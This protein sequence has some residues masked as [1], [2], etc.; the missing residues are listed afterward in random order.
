M[1]R[2]EDLL[3]NWRNELQRNEALR[4]LDMDELEQHLRDSIAEL[5]TK[6]LN[7][8]EAFYVASR[9]LGEH[10]ALGQEYGTRLTTEGIS[11]HD[12]GRPGSRS[13]QLYLPMVVNR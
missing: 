5:R 1:S 2:L 12:P 4:P 6:G 9:R 3:K 10:R 11:V 8:E 13:T 7:D